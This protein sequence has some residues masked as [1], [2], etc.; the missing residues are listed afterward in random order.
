MKEINGKFFI[1]GKE[2]STYT[3]KQNYYWMMGDNRDNSLDSRYFG[4]VPEDH[5]IGT[6]IFTWLSI[7]GLFENDP[8]GHPA[9]FKI[10]WDRMFRTVNTNVPL[11]EKTNYLPVFIILLGGYFVYDYFNKKKKK[12]KNK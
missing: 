11:Q 4:Y 8:Y 12:E 7:Q 10:R 5:I 6:P 1:N 2:T 9:K 3:I